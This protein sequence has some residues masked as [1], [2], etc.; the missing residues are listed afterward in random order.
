MPIIRPSKLI[1]YATLIGLL[2]G[3]FMW[4]DDTVATKTDILI[5]RNTVERGQIE[6]EMRYF[7]RIGL[8]NLSPEDKEA[9]VDLK[10]EKKENEKQHD[11]LL[12]LD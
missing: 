1:E 8:D 6:N 12:G 4:I 9:F 7:R 5:V 3:A 11:K 10:L 2:Y